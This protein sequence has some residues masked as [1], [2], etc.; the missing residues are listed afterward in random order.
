MPDCIQEQEDKKCEVRG[1]HRLFS[2][3]PNGALHIMDSAPET[4]KRK[5]IG[6]PGCKTQAAEL[7]L[8]QFLKTREQ[9]T[10]RLGKKR[11][12]IEKQ[13][14]SVFKVLALNQFKDPLIDDNRQK[15][16]V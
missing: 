1:Y 6:L 9:H 12:L 10:L 2:I 14:Q 15:L 11:Y 3:I 13:P 4:V 16:V 8:T 7:I 5:K